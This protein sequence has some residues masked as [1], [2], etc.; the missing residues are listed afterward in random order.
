MALV[1]QVFYNYILTRIES[2]TAQM[3]EAAIGVLDSLSE[4]KQKQ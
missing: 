4:Y 3:E 1:L 2:I